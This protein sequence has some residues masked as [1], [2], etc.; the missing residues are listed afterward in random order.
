M[1]RFVCHVSSISG[2]ERDSGKNNYD[3]IRSLKLVKKKIIYTYTVVR[4]EMETTN[5]ETDF[6][7]VLFKV[8]QPQRRLLMRKI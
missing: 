3:C 4:Q 8:K 2:L 6:C 5:A 1:F 7:P